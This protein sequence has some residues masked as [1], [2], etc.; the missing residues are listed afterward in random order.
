[1][2]PKSVIRRGGLSRGDGNLRLL[3]CNSTTFSSH[4]LSPVG[5]KGLDLDGYSELLMPKFSK[6]PVLC[7][8]TIS[9]CLSL[10]FL[11]KIYIR[12]TNLAEIYI[13]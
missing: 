8:L 11:P 6:Q 1:M 12:K 9:T 7:L 10:V 3:H 5:D 4:V 2:W 13:F